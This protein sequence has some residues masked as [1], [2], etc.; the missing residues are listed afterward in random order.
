MKVSDEK[1]RAS[2]EMVTDEDMK[3]L[4]EDMKNVE[5]HTFSDEF[6][7]K[8]EALLENPMPKAKKKVYSIPRYVA[9]AAAVVLVVGGFGIAGSTKM[10]ASET[11]IPVLQWMENFFV[12]EHDTDQM[13]GEKSSEVLFGQDQIGY[14]PEGFELVEEISRQSKV[15]YTYKN[16]EDEYIVL[17]VY[18]D[19]LLSGID[20]QDILKNQGINADGLEYWY[21]YKSESMEHIFT[22]LGKNEEF[23]ALRGTIDQEEMQKIMNSISY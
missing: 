18:S 9:A 16:V 8:M 17:N 12:T 4:E 7:K 21:M 19:K 2:I 14:V 22:W 5:P 10:Y 1:L 15:S 6:E 13:K 3:K 20:N 23:Y 11:K